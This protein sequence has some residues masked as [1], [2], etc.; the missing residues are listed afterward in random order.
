MEFM[1]SV[2]HDE[3]TPCAYYINGKRVCKEV[4]QHFDTFI[5][6]HGTFASLLVTRTN[7]TWQY[8]KTGT[9]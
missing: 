5:S 2:R 7:T 6:M 9:C 3:V 1:T 8:R 4:Y